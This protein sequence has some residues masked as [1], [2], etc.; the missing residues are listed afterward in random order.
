MLVPLHR[1]GSIVNQICLD[2]LD[3][4]DRAIFLVC[5]DQPQLLHDLHPA[6]DPSEYGM[7]AVQ[8]R[9]RRQRDEE[10]RA[11]GVRPGIGH[12]ENACTRVLELRGDF[13]FKLFAVDG[14]TAS[15]GAC[16]IASLYHEVW[17]YAVEDQAVEV[18]ALRE[19]G[20]VFACLGRMVVVEFDDDGALLW[21]TGLS[22][23]RAGRPTIVVSSATSVAMVNVEERV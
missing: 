9:S 15:T 17:N 5:L 12:A 22:V 20:E 2:D 8:P 13:V 7:L 18:V 4:L 14:F 6:L 23:A 11:I 1:K 10:L 21:L 19:R 3:L 16:G